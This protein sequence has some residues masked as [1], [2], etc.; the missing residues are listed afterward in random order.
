MDSLQQWQSLIGTCLVLIFGGIAW[1]LRTV[2]N[3]SNGITKHMTEQDALKK[4]VVELKEKVEEHH[5]Y[6]SFHRGVDAVAGTPHTSKGR[7]LPVRMA[8][9]GEP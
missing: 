9:K 7:V 1:T 8:Q 5:D 3:I 2:M 4:N 6:I